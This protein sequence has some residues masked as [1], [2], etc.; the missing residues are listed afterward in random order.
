[1]FCWWHSIPNL[2]QILDKRVLPSLSP[3]FD[4]PRLDRELRTMLRDR[5]SAFV[6]KCL[7]WPC[8][9]VT[10]TFDG[11]LEKFLVVT[12]PRRFGDVSGGARL[13]QEKIQLKFHRGLLARK[14]SKKFVAGTLRQGVTPNFSSKGQSRLAKMHKFLTKMCKSLAMARKM[15]L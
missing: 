6:G 9:I 10:L 13:R 1:M 2:F 14:N 5:F 11:T 3:L 7:W 15:S 8:F 12:K 4:N